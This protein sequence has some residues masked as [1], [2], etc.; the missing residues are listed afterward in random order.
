MEELLKSFSEVPPY[1]FNDWA[2]RGTNKGAPTAQALM[3]SGRFTNILIRLIDR[4]QDLQSCTA[5]IGKLV[6]LS[7]SKSVSEAVHQHAEKALRRIQEHG[8]E[9]KPG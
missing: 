5:G 9:V 6:E 3:E 4:T 8:V 1:L 2:S 7:K